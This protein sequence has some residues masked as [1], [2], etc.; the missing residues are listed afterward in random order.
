MQQD[1]L[2]YYEKATTDY[3]IRTDLPVNEMFTTIV[4]TMLTMAERYAIG[5]VWAGNNTTDYTAEL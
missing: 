5:L 2:H 1:F 3:S 4:H